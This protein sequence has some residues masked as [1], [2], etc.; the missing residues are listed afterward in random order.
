VLGRRLITADFLVTLGF[1]ALFAWAIQQAREWPFRAAL[2]PVLTASFVVGLILLKLV[3]D[4]ASARRRPP[5]AVSSARVDR[6]VPE[7]RPAHPSQPQAKQSATSSGRAGGPWQLGA[8]GTG[9]RAAFLRKAQDES[10][11]G[12]RTGTDW[13]AQDQ[14]RMHPAERVA[15]DQSSADSEL[16]DIFKVAQRQVWIAALGWMGAFFFSLWALGIFF[17]VPLFTFLYLRWASRESP[18]MAGAYAAIAWAFVF[19][20]FDRVLHIPL[21]SSALLGTLG[22]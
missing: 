10:D 20:V 15:S 14:T 1:L 5:V 3:L 18:L 9:P 16:E 17:A 7:N 21:P 2:F 8:G 11:H 4:V 13:R 19:G 22:L 12:G 6:G